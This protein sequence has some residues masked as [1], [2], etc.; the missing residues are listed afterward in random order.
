MIL[1]I[2]ATSPDWAN[3]PED[4]LLYIFSFLEPAKLSQIALVCKTW[5]GL[6]IDEHLW[7]YMCVKH[8]KLQSMPQLSAGQ[9]S[10][11][12]EYKRLYYHSPCIESEALLEHTDEVWHV[13][14]SHDG[15]RFAT[16]SKDGT[17]KVIII[18]FYKIVILK[19][20]YLDIIK[21]TL[22]WGFNC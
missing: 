10:W 4:V 9:S 7:K 5:N 11:R 17:I 8:Y 15:H 19:C 18:S 21:F 14:F 3:V 6:T 16:S 13:S 2:M 1:A 20:F 22:V 12:Q